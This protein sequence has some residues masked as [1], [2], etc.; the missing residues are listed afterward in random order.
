MEGY[1][2]PYVGKSD[3]YYDDYDAEKELDAMHDA[4]DAEIDF[5]EYLKEVER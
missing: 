5:L 1:Q 4:A 3:S 2:A